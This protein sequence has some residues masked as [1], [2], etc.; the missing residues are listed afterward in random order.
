MCKIFEP[1]TFYNLH[2][3]MFDFR[4]S[5]NCVYRKYNIHLENKIE[6]KSKSGA[7]L[8]ILARPLTRRVFSY[9]TKG[10]NIWRYKHLII[11]LTNENAL[12]C[13]PYRLTSFFVNLIG[14]KYDRMFIPSYVLIF[15]LIT[16][17]LKSNMCNL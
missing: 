16:E 11:F 15:R 8:I 1:S 5:G 13:L 4:I 10:Q 6:L 17:H 9:H 3:S 2:Y 14:Q 12:F 7:L